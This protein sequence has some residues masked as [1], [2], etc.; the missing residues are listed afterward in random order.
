MNTLAIINMLRDAITLA[1]SVGVDLNDMAARMDLN[2]G[3]LSDDDVQELLQQSQD[4]ID[5]L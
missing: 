4:A 1:R 5:R 3:E 2:G